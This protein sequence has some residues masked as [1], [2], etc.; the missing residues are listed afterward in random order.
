MSAALDYQTPN[1]SAPGRGARRALLLLLLIN[2][3]NYIDRYMMGAVEVPIQEHFFPTH[4]K[5]AEFRMGLLQTGFIVCYMVCAPL[6]GWLADRKSR[7]AIVGFSVI[8]WSLAT[9]G[10]G[11]AAMFGGFTLLLVM[12]ILVGVG[13]AGY[14]PT[15]PTLISDYYPVSRRGA[16]MAWFYMA[17]PLGAALGYIIG[18]AMAQHFGWP[19]AFYAV[20]VPGLILG[21]ICFLMKEPARGQFD[22]AAAGAAGHM[23]VRRA[24]LADYLVLFRTPSYVLVTAGMAAMTFAVSG[25]AYWLP[26]YIVTIRHGGTL[27][28]ANFKIGAITAACGIFGTLLGGALGDWL[29]RWFSSSYFLLS[30]I[31]MIIA[32]PFIIF[33]LHST[34]PMVWV[35]IGIAEF[36]LFLNTGPTNT[37]LANVAHPSVRATG[38]ALNI[39]IIHIFGDALATPLLGRIGAY[40]WDAAFIMVATVMALAGVLWLWGC[41]YLQRDTELAPRRLGA[42]AEPQA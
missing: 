24:A 31:A 29:R 17:I 11:L 14:G 4:P 25:I 15:A 26:R 22:E 3:F 7:W 40:S 33:M 8:L 21:A 36:F 16:M 5:Y 13:E 18:G 37:I 12:R 41:S 35:C 23:P 39:F 20:L 28:S 34:F 30:G 10:S 42:A 6:F 2:L 38:F 32:A 9:G 27:A 19:S 1:L